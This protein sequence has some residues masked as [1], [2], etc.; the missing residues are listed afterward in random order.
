[1]ASESESF[2]IQFVIDDLKGIKQH[3]P[4]SQCIFRVPKTLLNEKKEAYIP[5]AIG[6]GP[7][8]WPESAGHR[9]EIELLKTEAASKIYHRMG[10]TNFRSMFGTI[11]DKDQETRKKY[12][13]EICWDANS[14]AS[15]IITDACFLVEVL[16]KFSNKQ[17]REDEDKDWP[18]IDRVLTRKRNHPLLNEIV[19]DMLKMESQ[20]PLW[21]LQNVHEKTVE[22]G[23]DVFSNVIRMMWRSY[24]KSLHIKEAKENRENFR[25]V[26]NLKSLGIKFRNCAG[27]ISSIHFDIYKFIL[28][29]PYLR[30]DDRLEVML[31]NLI[32]FEICSSMED[33]AVTRYVLFMRNLISTGTDVSILE[34]EG[35]IT[36]KLGSDDEASQL[37]NSI[38][39]SIQSTAYAPID[40]AEKGISIYCQRKWQVLWAQFWMIDCSQPWLVVSFVA[41][42]ILLLMT[43]AQVVCLFHSCTVK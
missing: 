42:T 5:Q 2:T 11:L 28:Y 23:G 27:G 14:F 29:I 12:D 25:S 10:D 9:D 1:M 4:T 35:I 38:T 21:L 39:K 30:I 40:Y 26:E 13:Q 16:T 7:Y 31:R 3:D 8:H 17:V 20:L 37:F 36:N 24:V 15:F 6:L 33:K 43:A 32:A 34:N 22:Q 41:A 19:K 18:R